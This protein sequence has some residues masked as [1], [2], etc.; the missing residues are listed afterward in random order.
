MHVADELP[1]SEGPAACVK[2]IAGIDGATLPCLPGLPPRCWRRAG[3][4]RW[5]RAWRDYFELRHHPIVLVLEDVA[6]EHIHAD[7]ISEL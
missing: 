6:M 1:A 7:V 3:P 4:W 5:A 2:G